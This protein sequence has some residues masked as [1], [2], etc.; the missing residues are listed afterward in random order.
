[1]GKSTL[2]V[3]FLLVAGLALSLAEPVVLTTENFKKM[4][5]EKT[6]PVSLEAGKHSVS[7]QSGVMQTI[8]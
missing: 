3:G 6:S 2:I 8:W 7:Y 1:M 5:R 4:V